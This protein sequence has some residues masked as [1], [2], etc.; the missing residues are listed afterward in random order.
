MSFLGAGYVANIFHREW[1]DKQSLTLKKKAQASRTLK[2]ANRYEAAITKEL[3][4]KQKSARAQFSIEMD[5][6]ALANVILGQKGGSIFKGL[7]NEGGVVDQEKLKDANNQ[8]LYNQF[9]QQIQAQRT[10]LQNQLTQTLADLEAKAELDK[11]ELVEPLK[12][13]GEDLQVESDNLK[14][15]ADV[16]KANYEEAKKMREENMKSMWS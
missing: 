3:R 11:E 13:E 16:A 2:Q 7:F 5:T 6:S 4:A 10:A 12:E 8:T 1:L 15:E 9:T 14:A